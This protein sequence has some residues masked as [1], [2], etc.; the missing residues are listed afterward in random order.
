M[1]IKYPPL[2]SVD[3][4]VKGVRHLIGRIVI[5]VTVRNKPGTITLEAAE[6]RDL[7]ARINTALT[8]G[9]PKKL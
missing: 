6:A 8:G 7:A 2:I 1:N 5:D 4:E 9:T 3:A